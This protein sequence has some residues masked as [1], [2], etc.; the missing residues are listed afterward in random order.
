M[1]R[2]ETGIK[3]SF[4]VIFALSIVF[5]LIL[6]Y[7]G[8]TVLLKDNAEPIKNDA[9][10]TVKT[11][12][13]VSLKDIPRYSGQ[14]FVMVNNNKPVFSSS[15]MSNTSYERYAPLD[16]LGRCRT[17][18]A[19]VGKDIMPKKKR[20][21]ISSVKPSGWHISKYDDVDGKYL[22]NRCHLIGYQLTGENANQRN[23]I[24]GTRYLNVEGMLP[25]ENMVADYVKETGNHVMYKATP[26]FE[27]DDLV[28]K[29]VQIEGKSV[30]DNGEAIEFNVFIYNV[31][32]GI[33]IDYKTGENYAE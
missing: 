25:F 27:G 12:D 9:G 1:S 4:G 15:E 3:K 11:G 8:S 18:I 23:L 2:K 13:I 32:P 30:E 5:I 22:Y 24:T 26:I 20:G 16:N 31:Q 21:S 10:A 33:H 7:V 17:A 14:P 29:G 28:A 6:S 19:C